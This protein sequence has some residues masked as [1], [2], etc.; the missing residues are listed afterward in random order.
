MATNYV[1]VECID[2]REGRSELSYHGYRNPL[3][4]L[5]LMTLKIL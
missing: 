3:R 2:T 5:F 1:G 4:L